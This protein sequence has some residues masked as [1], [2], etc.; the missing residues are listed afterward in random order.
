M[1]IQ[2]K[3]KK[4]GEDFP[5]GIIEVDDKVME[6]C[7]GIAEA[8]GI[9]LDEWFEETLKEYIRKQERICCNGDIICTCEG[10]CEK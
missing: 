5:D 6:K 2:L 9:S 3:N 7:F 10:D 4:T 1:I 8:Q